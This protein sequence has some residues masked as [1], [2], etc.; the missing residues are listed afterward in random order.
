MFVRMSSSC[1][2]AVRTVAVVLV[3]VVM[4]AEAVKVLM[5]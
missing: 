5:W 1:S 4:A 3:A 2:R